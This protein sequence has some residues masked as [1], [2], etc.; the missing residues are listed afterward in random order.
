MYSSQDIAERIKGR[1]KQQGV[2]IKNMLEFCELG[3]NTVVKMT[4]G[5]DIHTKNFAKIAD[6]LDCS[7]DY[8]LGRTDNPE[9]NKSISIPIS[10]HLEQ[11]VKL[12]ADSTE[13]T[14]I[15]ARKKKPRMTE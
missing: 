14:H 5:T 2:S 3:K 10:K 12:V 13:S 7:V 1:A 4:G 6:Y 8:L 9:I 15:N 11:N